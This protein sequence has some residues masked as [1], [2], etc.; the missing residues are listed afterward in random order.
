MGAV[1]AD[2]QLHADNITNGIGQEFS[3]STDTLYSIANLFTILGEVNSSV[4]H[5]FAIKVIKNKPGILLVEW[6]P[7]V[8]RGEV[9]SFL[10]K[11]SE[12]GVEN[13]KMVEPDSSGEYIPAKPKK[14]HFP[15]LFSVA[16]FENL[17]S[18]GLDL[19]WSYERMAS[20]YLARDSGLAAAS[21]T[22]DIFLTSKEKSRE[23]PGFA[24]TIP[25]YST[26]SEPETV[27]GRQ[28]K[29]RGYLAAVFYT[30]GLV[31]P[32]EKYLVKNNLGIRMIDKGTDKTVFAKVEDALSIGKITNFLEIYGQ[33]WEIQVFPKAGYL[34][35]YFLFIDF[36]FPVSLLIFL[37]FL[38]LI[39]YRNEKQNRV[40]ARIQIQLENAL[41][42][43][44]AAAKSKMTFLAN[45]SHE[46]RTPLNAIIG[47]AHLLNVDVNN[48]DKKLY[49]SRMISN[50]ELLQNTIDDILEISNLEEG[51]VL[52]NFHDFNLLT[53]VEELKDLISL[54][55]KNE[56]VEFKVDLKTD[57]H[58]FHGDSFRIRQILINLLSNSLKFTDKGHVKLLCR[59]DKGDTFNLRFTVI[60][61]GIGIDPD[62]LERATAA[63][64]QEDESFSRSKG[65]VGL[66]LY[67]TK[68]LVEQLDGKFDIHS[69]KNKGTTIEVRIP[70]SKVNSANHREGH[71]LVLPALNKKIVV[72]EDDFDAQF[73]LKEYLKGLGL[74]LKFVS[75]GKELIEEVINGAYD[76]VITDVQMPVLDGL[77]AT[78][79]LRKKGV[80]IPVLAMS[81]HTL[82]EEKEK[83]FRAGVDAYIAKPISKDELIKSIIDIFKV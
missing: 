45:M 65:G 71:S 64:S 43:A 76:L 41:E 82:V 19:A 31:A 44:K 16:K 4:F 30:D 27:K 13:F 2:L 79:L 15:V 40:L 39:L 60:D 63:F 66:G 61:T 67:I 59:E 37:L 54:N 47:Y 48:D 3:G 53:L 29:F 14:E 12:L 38:I 21:N 57:H 55:R 73:I 28:D 34:K 36:L 1:K 20:K 68:K 10:K 83:C 70:V 24:I 78:R 81:A 17:T 8:K 72:A 25:I 35:K 74:N 26:K 58:F 75:N 7:R 42:D 49:T 11:T 46:I 6:Q 22:F 9:S 62:Y 51:K 80:A 5:E 56:E 69:E 32:I 33:K 18:I 23:H 50:G 52:L 77:E